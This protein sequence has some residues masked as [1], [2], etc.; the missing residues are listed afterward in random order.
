LEARVTYTLDPPPCR[1][2]SVA[3]QATADSAETALSPP[4][5]ASVRYT[6][7]VAGG[8]PRCG[9]K[10]AQ[11]LSTVPAPTR[12][13]CAEWPG[14][15][16]PALARVQCAP[17]QGAKYAVYIQYRSPAIAEQVYELVAGRDAPRSC[18]TFRDGAGTVQDTGG[19]RAVTCSSGA[20]GRAHLTWYDD[21]ASVFAYGDG[22]DG[23]RDRL[24]AWWRRSG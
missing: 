8:L 11:L 4:A 6:G 24:L 14:V 3:S 21:G 22:V 15:P 12:A 10:L 23:D 18:G 20:G 2:P 1:T 19:K 16:A 7:L 9:T 5:V 17:K 13:S